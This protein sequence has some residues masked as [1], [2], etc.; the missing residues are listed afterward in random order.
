MTTSI[1]LKMNDVGS[2]VSVISGGS[3]V[4][5]TIAATTLSMRVWMLSV[6]SIMFLF[7]VSMSSLSL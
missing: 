3:G 7:L 5:L 6:S 1:M 2:L 4:P